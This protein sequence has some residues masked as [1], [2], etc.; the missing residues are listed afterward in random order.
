MSE[1][2]TALTGC[3]APIDKDGL[4]TLIANGKA[5]PQAIKT[6]KC[7]TVAGDV[8]DTPTISAIWNLTSWTNHRA[9]WAM[10]QRQTHRKHRWP[11]WAVASRW[12]CTP[13]RSTGA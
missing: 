3:L 9:C 13:T 7:K 11:L 2:A 6:L 5:N 1:P 4:N 12:A 10:T 8:S